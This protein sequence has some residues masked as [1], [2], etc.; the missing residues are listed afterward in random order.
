M[1]YINLGFDYKTRKN[2][3]SITKKGQNLVN[4]L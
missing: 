3:M 2:T 4:E 1:C